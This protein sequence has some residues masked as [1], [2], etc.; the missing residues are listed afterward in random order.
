[1]NEPHT[2]DV[3]TPAPTDATSTASVREVP[4]GVNPDAPPHARDA[5]IAYRTELDD[6]LAHL[7]AHPDE[8]WVAYRGGQRVGFGTDHRELLLACQEKFPDGLFRVYGIDGADKYPGNTV[9]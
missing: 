3:T 4:L 9:V 6:L 8:R 7:A 5:A 2:A 1:M